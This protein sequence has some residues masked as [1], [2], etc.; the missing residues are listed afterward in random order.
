MGLPVVA[1]RRSVL[2]PACRIVTVYV[3]SGTSKANEPSLALSIDFTSGIDTVAPA[4]GCPAGSRTTPRIVAADAVA[5]TNIA[6]KKN[7]RNMKASL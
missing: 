7:D 3:P 2:K 1:S 6:M 4:T 5:P